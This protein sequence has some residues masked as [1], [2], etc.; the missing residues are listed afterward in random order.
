LKTQGLGEGI[1]D[2]KGFRVA[3]FD[4]KELSFHNI[5]EIL[6]F[7]YYITLDENERR[8]LLDFIEQRLT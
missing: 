7:K 4:F 3:V 8:R 5:Y 2:S 1:F 6:F